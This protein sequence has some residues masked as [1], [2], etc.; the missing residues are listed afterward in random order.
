MALYIMPKVKTFDV[1]IGNQ[2]IKKCS[3][4]QDAKHLLDSMALKVDAY[5]A[6]ADVKPSM[7]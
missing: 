3:T 2:L 6:T 7:C 5:K 1:M 4:Y